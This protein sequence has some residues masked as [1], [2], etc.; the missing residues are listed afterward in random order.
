MLRISFSIIF[1]P[2]LK[3][4]AM[5]KAMT[6]YE[7]QEKHFKSL[8]LLTKHGTGMKDNFSTARM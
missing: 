5:S 4:I 8:W 2:L 6:T 1:L 7:S 3:L